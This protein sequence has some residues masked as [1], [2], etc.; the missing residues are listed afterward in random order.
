MKVVIAIVLVFFTYITIRVV[1]AIQCYQCG[2]AGAD[3]CKK[4]SDDFGK[5]I[6]CAGHC[7]KMFLEKTGEFFLKNNSLLACMALI[8]CHL[9]SYYSTICSS[10]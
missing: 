7:A 3:D 4:D 9:I 2:L 8:D 10:E 6:D 1:D 5:L